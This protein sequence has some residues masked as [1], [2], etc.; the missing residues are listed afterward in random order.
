MKFSVVIIMR[1]EEETLP[2]LAASLSAFLAGGG[3]WIALDTGSTD[4]T[5]E[6]ARSLGAQV[7]EVGDRFV[8]TITEE[9]ARQISE[10]F[11]RDGKEIVEA[12]DKVFDFSSARNFAAAIASNDMICMPD[13]DEAFTTFDVP[14]IEQA[15]DSA[16]QI[17]YDFVYS[18][19]EDGTPCYQFRHEK[20]YSRSRAQWVGIVHEV[21]QGDLRNAYLPPE[22]IS[23]EHFQN[24]KTNRSGYLKGLA[25]DCLLHPE[26]DRNCHYFGRELAGC[27]YLLS[28]IQELDRHIAM[29]AWDAERSQSWILKGDIF[30]TLGREDEAKAAWWE[31]FKV[32]PKRRTAL[33]RLARYHWSRGEH[34]QVAVF[35]EACLPIKPSGFYM[36]DG[37]EDRHIPHEFLYWALWYMGEKKRAKEHFEKA[38]A[39]LPS[40]P[41]LLG[42]RQFFLD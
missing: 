35:A 22:V 33:L 41:K 24:A 10:K 29:N 16:T 27:G 32:Y 11:A 7:F 36:D 28:A 12:G 39:F 15:L 38:L 5:V 21:L 34:A 17:S 4:K 40:D 3:E 9:E 30:L 20:F 6:V 13:A 26:N 14:L 25:L 8:R 31:A 37:A 18:R 23:L 1:N 2:R 42:D 19:K